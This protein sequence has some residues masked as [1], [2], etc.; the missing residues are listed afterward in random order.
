MDGT[1]WNEPLMQR[2]WWLMKTPEGRAELERVAREA[3]E[4]SD[5]F[6]DAIHIEDPVDLHRPMTI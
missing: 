3:K 1:G 4:E 5:K 6:L 2:L